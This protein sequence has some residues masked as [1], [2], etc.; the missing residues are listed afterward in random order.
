MYSP[1][2]AHVVVLLLLAVAL[3]I[4]GQYWHMARGYL[5]A[6]ALAITWLAWSI[7]RMLWIDRQPEKDNYKPPRVEPE[8][9]RLEMTTRDEAGNLQNKSII[10]LPCTTELLRTF[11]DTVLNFNAPLSERHWIGAGFTPSGWHQFRD[12]M[13]KRGYIAA[14]TGDPRGGYSLTVVGRNFLKKILEEK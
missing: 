4:S 9:M 2:P 7:A 1:T 12:E 5:W 13:V 11:A 6:G 10:D 8:T 3:G 14:P